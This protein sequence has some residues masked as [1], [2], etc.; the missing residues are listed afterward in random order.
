[1]ETWGEY[2]PLLSSA[3]KGILL[4]NACKNQLGPMFTK[5]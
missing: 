2:G 5:G 4:H 1:M 3:V